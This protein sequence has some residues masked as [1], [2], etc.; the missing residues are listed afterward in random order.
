[1]PEPKCKVVVDGAE[2]GGAHG[3]W[4][5]PVSTSQGTTGNLVTHPAEETEVCQLPGLYEVYRAEFSGRS[6][7]G[8]AGTLM[9]DNGSDTNYVRHEF[10][11]S[12]G[13]QG[14]PHRC[15]LKV[16]DTDYRLVETAK[17]HLTVV[18]KDGKEHQVVA[19]GLDSITTLPPD[20]DLSPLVPLLEGVPL[21]VLERPQGQVDV[22]LG[23]RD[24]ALH[25]RDERQWGNLCLLRSRF[26]CGW[27]L[28]GT[29]GSLKFTGLQA[30]PSYSAGLHALRNSAR[31]RT[32]AAPDL[33]MCQQPVPR[34][35]K[36]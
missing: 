15:R 11:L 4:F 27:A 14:E 25:G 35:F 17:Y 12:L 20:P 36:S 9:I 21:Q 16:V 5:H 31:R 13:L 29:H 34:S 24:S 7:Q 30:R 26:G 19:L 23:L 3:R 18:D 10:A 6:G 1:M 33:S 32:R 2:C 8:Q 22:L 28:R